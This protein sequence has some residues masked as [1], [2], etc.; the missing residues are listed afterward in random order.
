MAGSKDEVLGG[1]KQ[2]LGKLTGDK[3]LEAEG[4]AQKTGGR[5]ARKTRGAAR[6]L[7]GNV[8]RAAGDVLDSPTL[9]A[10]G[11]LDRAHGRIER[12]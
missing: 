4:A 10:E 7:K 8:K 12:A 11:N 3:A 5:A 6:E 2:G 1:V 9:E